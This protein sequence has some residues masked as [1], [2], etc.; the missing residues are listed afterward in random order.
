MLGLLLPSGIE[1]IE[2]FTRVANFDDD[3]EP[4]G[5]EV[6]LQAVNPL[7]SPCLM[8]VGTVRVELYEFVPASADN[9]GRRL[10]F[11]NVELRDA[12]DQARHWNRVT[13]MYEF[14]LAVNPVNVPPLAERYVL[15]VTYNSPLG[16]HVSD[17]YV[18]QTGPSLR[19]AP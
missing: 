1:I 6:M 14:R 19:G 4:D 18:L 8:M 7:D 15:A 16:D 17:E 11:W 5:I 12:E 3:A 2:P 9:K 13:Q 10:E